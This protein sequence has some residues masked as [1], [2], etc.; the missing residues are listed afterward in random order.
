MIRRFPIAECHPPGRLRNRV[1][2]QIR[3]ERHCI[4][5]PEQGCCCKPHPTRQCGFVRDSTLGRQ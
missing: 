1:D 4:R 2:G 5:F 3:A